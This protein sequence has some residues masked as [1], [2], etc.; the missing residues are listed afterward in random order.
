MRRF[1]L[2]VAA[3]FFLGAC[4]ASGQTVV[5]FNRDVRPILADHCFACHGP[6]ARQ[7]KADLR[8]DSAESADPKR[9]NGP[10]VIAGDPAKSELWR[11]INSTD[12]DEQMPPPGKGRHLI[13]SELSILKQWITQGAKFEKHWSLLPVRRPAVVVGTLRVPSWPVN[14]LDAFILARLEK[15]GLSPSPP[16]GKPTLL[17]RVTLGLTG[18]PPSPDEVNAFLTDPAPDAYERTVDRLLASPR[19]GERMA[20]PWLDAARYADTSGYQSD[21][22]R[23][24]WRWRD[25]VIEALNANMPFDQ[26]TI[27]QI[28][29]DLLPNP[30]LDQR[31]A[32]GFN[33]NHRGNAEGG[34][35]PEEYA[36]EYVADRVETTATV[37]LGLTLGCAR[38]HDHKYDPFTQRD[39]Y[40]LFAFF[41]NVPEKGRAIKIGNSPPYIQAPT[42]L[43]AEELEFLT[44]RH[45]STLERF[46]VETNK[47][48]D[49]FVPWHRRAEKMRL[50]DWYPTEQ[51][52]AHFPLDDLLEE[53]ISR[54]TAVIEG[55]T[56]FTDGRLKSAA[57]FDGQT[58]IALDKIGDF[59]FFDKFTIS[60]WIKLDA[61][62]GGTVVSRMVDVP[63]GE[64]YQLAVTRGKLQLNLVKRWLDDALRVETADTL[65]DM[66]W[67]HVAASYDGSRVAE[68]VKL[69]IDGKVQKLNVLLDEL[70][71]SFT[72][73]EPFRIGAGGGAPSRFRGAIDEVR[74]YKAVLPTRDV[75]IL[76]TRQSIDEILAGASGLATTE[77]LYEYYLWN[78]APEALRD[79]ER[80]TRVALRELVAFDEKLPTVMVMDEIPAPRETHVLLRGQYDKPG[81]RVEPNVPPALPPL[82]VGKLRVPPGATAG[83]SPPNRLDLARWLVDRSNPL[84]SRVFVNRAW[85]HHFG[86]GI[87]KTSEDF[88]LQGEWPSH[89]DLLDWLASEFATEWDMKRLQR[90]IVTSATY[91]QSSFS[92]SQ[93]AIRTPQSIDPDNR[94]LWRGPRLRLSAEM[95]RDQALFA[96]GM[97]V[98]QLGGPSV[99]PLQPAGLWSELTGGDD[100][101]PGAGADLV[102]RSL[103]TFWKRTIPPPTL[104]AFDSPSREACVVRQSRTNTPLQALVLLNEPTFVATAKTLAQLVMHEATSP[105]ERIERAMLRVLGR[106]PTIEESKIL[107]AALSRYLS[108]PGP[109]L[110]PERREKTTQ[111]ELT[112]YSLICSTILNLD[113]AVTSQ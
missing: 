61:D 37:W 82:V 3:A 14:A 92:N 81:E 107:T 41:N 10:V 36:V 101:Q 5:E 103:Y 110:V 98:E 84:T 104:S 22:E 30:T 66:N 46:D 20:I 105:P 112:A 97:L 78:H 76:A 19:C 64:G 7:R 59:G 75:Q 38:C 43:Q 94:L 89:P 2:T 62:G 40:S 8:L 6:D 29:G 34:I 85:Q 63:E 93:S 72:T 67:H 96:S 1:A 106:K 88:G 45:I 15:E 99:K 33:R 74:V 87:V 83:S 28:A 65:I 102:R 56:R 24:M 108:Q 31:I 71:Q 90:S 91:R 27:E 100:Y 44:N 25:W 49:H 80:Q 51:L 21:G 79:A 77:K 18:L 57:L 32:T 12:P 13:D 54:R 9:E 16:A 53:R 4:E 95:I 23:Y 11:R 111:T 60:A 69:F 17:R 58:A 42:R 55:E 109:N 68:G 35:I 70:N 48:L 39:F 73:K 113:E 86:T 52:A 47:L 50:G 26:F